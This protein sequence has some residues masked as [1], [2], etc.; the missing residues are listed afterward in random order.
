MVNDDP[1]LRFINKYRVWN[2]PKRYTNDILLN[3]RLYF[4]LRS[5]FNDPF[6]VN[7]VYGDT[8][9]ANIVLNAFRIGCFSRK[10]DNIL[11]WSNYA[12][13]HKGICLKFDV[14]KAEKCFSYPA[15]MVYTNKRT[16]FVE[17]ISSDRKGA[18]IFLR[19][20]I[21]WSFEDEVRVLKTPTMLQE[22]GGSPFFD[23]DPKALVEV[24][25]GARAEQQTIDEV[26]SVCSEHG[27][28]HVKFARMA[29]KDDIEFKL[30]KIYL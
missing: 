26:M 29:L 21:D 16:N 10:D 30:E 15:C 14:L 27:F 22:N 12:A 1:D 8:A 3:H 7:P 25:F 28:E 13:D 4:A 24:I 18:E 11:L 9:L 20:F 17:S 19:K 23:F 5:E 2:D 6:D